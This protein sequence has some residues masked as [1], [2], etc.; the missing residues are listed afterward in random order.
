MFGCCASYRTIVDEL[1]LLL[2]L[3]VLELLVLDVLELLVLDVLELLVP[4]V[5]EL[6]VTDVP[7]VLVLDVLELDVPDV[8][9]LE[10]PEVVLPPDRDSTGAR[11]AVAKASAPVTNR[12]IKRADSTSATRWNWVAILCFNEFTPFAL[13][14]RC[15]SRIRRARGGGW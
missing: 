2:V 13:S 1:E 15:S 12:P 14:F 11:S 5:P 9:E 7:E 4:D 3:D 10:V 6:L 8:P